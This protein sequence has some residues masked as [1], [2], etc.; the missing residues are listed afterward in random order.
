MNELKL[1]EKI[2]QGNQIAKDNLL[3][4]YRENFIVPLARQYETIGYKLEKLIEAAE[5]GMIDAALDFQLE[6]KRFAFLSFAVWWTRRSI[7]R[8]MLEPLEKMPLQ[9][10]D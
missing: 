2:K 4:L 1:I 6:E 10:G 3:S 7:I 9:A 8:Y 5:R